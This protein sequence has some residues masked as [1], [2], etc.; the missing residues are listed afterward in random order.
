[1]ALCCQDDGQKV[2]MAG[3]DAVG[4]SVWDACYSCM[5]ATAQCCPAESW[6]EICRKLLA[7]DCQCRLLSSFHCFSCDSCVTCISLWI[8]WWQLSLW[9]WRVLRR[10]RYV[11]ERT[12]PLSQHVGFTSSNIARGFEWQAWQFRIFRQ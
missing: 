12:Q 2:V 9:R 8:C 6:E 4:H 7:S 1:M 3:V 11:P 5:R 10:A